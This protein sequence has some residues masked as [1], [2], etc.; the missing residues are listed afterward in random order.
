MA[1]KKWK[2]NKL[3]K[4]K[5]LSRIANIVLS[6][7]IKNLLCYVQKYQTTKDIEDLHDVR[8]ALRRVRYNME[9]FYVCFNKTFFMKLYSAIEK[10]QDLSG[11]LR[12]LDVFIEKINS[13][14]K[15]NVEVNEEIELRINQKRILLQQKFEKELSKFVK[16][17][18]LK[19]FIKVIS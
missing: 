6:F 17:K 7:R 4:S 5:Q 15:E 12:D 10:L 9:I 18:N 13:L 1:K 8:I 11:E 19:S 2:I 16:N 3:R 14:K